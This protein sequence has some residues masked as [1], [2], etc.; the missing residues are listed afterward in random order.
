M[1]NK[2]E[3]L[4]STR[5]KD[6]HLARKLGLTEVDRWEE[7]IPHHPM[8]EKLMVFLAD[9]DFVDFSDSFCWKTGGDGDNGETLMYQMDTFFELLD[10]ENIHNKS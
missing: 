9:H 3:R 1:S 4:K 2:E 6:Y 7:G 5:S 10:K 8:S